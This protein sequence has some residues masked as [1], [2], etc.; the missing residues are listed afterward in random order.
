MEGMIRKGDE[1]QEQGQ[2]GQSHAQQSLQIGHG[3]EPAQ[4][5][6]GQSIAKTI[7]ATNPH[8]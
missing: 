6:S 5:G 7:T 2:Q 3:G 1:R 8:D 4:G